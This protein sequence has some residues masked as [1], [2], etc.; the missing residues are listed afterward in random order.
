[1]AP[2][3]ARICLTGAECTGKSTL[4][5]ELALHYGTVAIPEFAREYAERVQRELTVDDVEPIARGQIALQGGTILD[6]DLISTV[7]YARHHYGSCPAWIVD[8]AWRR[9]ADLYLLMACDQPWV[10]DGVRDSGARRDELHGEFE[11]AL[12]EFGA[13]FVTISGGWDERRRQAIAAI[14]AFVSSR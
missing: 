3:A 7:V 10:A 11:A 6:T 12:R 9:K 4:A 14:D 1:M 2:L 8:E 13:R 5:A